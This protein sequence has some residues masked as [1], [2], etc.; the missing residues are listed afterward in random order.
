MSYQAAM[1]SSPLGGLLREARVRA[2]LTQRGLARRAGTSQSVVARIE[3]GRTDPSTATLARLLAAA[4][5]ELRT[6]L[7]PIAVGDTHMLED[8]PRILSLTPEERLLEV[9]NLS[10]LE[11]AARR[12]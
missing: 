4:G 1:T 3:Q 8:V 7:A 11:A 6:E 12:A 9:R 5:F 10:R 2:G